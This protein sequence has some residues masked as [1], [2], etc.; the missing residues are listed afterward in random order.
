M[1]TTDFSQIQT[2]YI[3]GQYLPIDSSIA[4]FD[5]INPATGEVIATLQHA[6]EE[7]VNEAVAVAKKAQKQWASMLPVERCRILSVF[8]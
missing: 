8:C 5:T 6:T 7:Q 4:T 1:N 3:N 2:S